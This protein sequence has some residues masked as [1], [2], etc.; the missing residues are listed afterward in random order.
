MVD[1]ESMYQLLFHSVTRAVQILTDAQKDT[2]RLYVESD[3]EPVIA[4]PNLPTDELES[5]GSQS[6]R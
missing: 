2:E 6:A 1:Y 4:G 5:N 3:G